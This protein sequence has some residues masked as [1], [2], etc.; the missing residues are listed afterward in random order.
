[1]RKSLL[2]FFVA[3]CTAQPALAA[4]DA[5]SELGEVV[6]RLNA[7]DTWIDDAGR[8]LAN[9]QKRLS[10]ADRGI[11]EVAA[12]T[13]A[14]GTQVAAAAAD[15][16]GLAAQREQLKAR[17]LTQ[18]DYIAEHLRAGWRLS[19][20]AFVKALLNQEDPAVYER[21][22]RYHGYFANARADATAEYRATLSTLSESERELRQQRDS[23]QAA[24]Q[25]LDNERATL[26]RERG[27]R[28]ELIAGLRTDL[29]DKGRER[30]QLE[31]SRERLAALIADLERQ[32]AHAAAEPVGEGLGMAGDLPWPVEG[33]VRRRFGE[34]RASGRMR[35]Q[36][37]LI[38][39]PLG[40]DIRAVAAGHVVFADW[41]RGFGLLAIVDHG[42]DH[43]SLYGY[44]DVLHK[45]AGDRVEGGEIIATIG[46]SGGQADVGL[47][48]EIRQSGEPI[49]P[50][51]WLQ[52][53]TRN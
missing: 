33:Q 18:A 4:E 10:S 43:M 6:R 34:V 38:Q 14:L 21:M 37:M 35:W 19:G 42:D 30:E 3:A 17:R 32:A 11:A 31:S 48:F 1:M 28:R 7:L 24:R 52:S 2:A 51:L 12:R 46:Q 36:G 23:L 53:R 15:L 45:R 16:E 41:L 39:A 5:A 29:S 25:T 40:S 27:K 50:R 26:L 8:R 20:G 44:A 49:D 9:Q 13:R 47:Y 22:I